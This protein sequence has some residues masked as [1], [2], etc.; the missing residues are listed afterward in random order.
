MTIKLSTDALHPWHGGWCDFHFTL[1]NGDKGV[2]T[3]RT[4]SNILL[5]EF[6]EESYSWKRKLLKQGEGVYRDKDL[7]FNNDC[8]HCYTL[9]VKDEPPKP[10]LIKTKFENVLNEMNSKY[11]ID[12][13]LDLPESCEEVLLHEEAN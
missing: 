10:G 11:G 12:L 1:P 9:V 2:I 7:G 8:R 13:E 5:S 3:L 6:T 4:M